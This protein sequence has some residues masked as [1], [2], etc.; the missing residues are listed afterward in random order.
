MMTKPAITERNVCTC[1]PVGTETKTYY[2]WSCTSN[3]KR[4]IQD[5]IEVY[6]TGEAIVFEKSSLETVVVPRDDIFMVTCKICSP[7]PCS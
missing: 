7:P 1:E 6:V 4:D 5:V 3:D 2:V